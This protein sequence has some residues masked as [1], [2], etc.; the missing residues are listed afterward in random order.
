MIEYAHDKCS[1][2]GWLG[3]EARHTA[4]ELG[5]EAW[6]SEDGPRDNPRL[7]WAQYQEDE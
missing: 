1:T 6:I 7:H 4:R 3:L 2:C 5:K